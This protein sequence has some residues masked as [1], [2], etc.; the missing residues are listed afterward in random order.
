LIE[1]AR[2]VKDFLGRGGSG[3]EYGIGRRAPALPLWGGGGACLAIG[4]AA[5]VWRLP[6][7]SERQATP[8]GRRLRGRQLI[9]PVP[10]EGTRALRPQERRQRR[11]L[12]GSLYKT[13]RKGLEFQQKGPVGGRHKLVKCLKLNNTFTLIYI[14]I[15]VKNFIYPPNRQTGTDC[16]AAGPPASLPRTR[17]RECK[18]RPL[19]MGDKGW[20]E[21]PEPRTHH[22][23]STISDEISRA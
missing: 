13:S 16:L 19:P 17:E 7:A 3:A 10:I 23:S 11:L 18:K 14:Y 15:S 12:V 9:R 5:P 22:P 8:L 1:F 4:A 21:G 2:V 20:G 6:Q